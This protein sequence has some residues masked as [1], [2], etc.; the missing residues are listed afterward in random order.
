MLDEG[1][2]KHLQQYSISKSREMDSVSLEDDE[3]SQLSG[4]EGDTVASVG[5]NLTSNSQQWGHLPSSTHFS[6]NYIDVVN[7][8]TLKFLYRDD[9][10]IYKAACNESGYDLML[11]PPDRKITYYFKRQIQFR[12]EFFFLSRIVKAVRVRRVVLLAEISKIQ[13]R[14]KELQEFI[15]VCKKKMDFHLNRLNLLEKELTLLT[16]IDDFKFNCSFGN[17]LCH[18]SGWN[19]I[20]PS[21][22]KEYAFLKSEHVASFEIENDEQKKNSK[23]ARLGL[24]LNEFDSVW[25]VLKFWQ[26]IISVALIARLGLDRYRLSSQE[27]F[28]VANSAYEMM[29]IV[30]VKVKTLNKQQSSIIKNQTEEE[31][32]ESKP[33]SP[34][35][36]RHERLNVNGFRPLQPLLSGGETGLAS[37]ENI[38]SFLGVSFAGTSPFHFVVQHCAVK[39]LEMMSSNA[40]KFLSILPTIVSKLSLSNTIHQ[41]RNSG[42]IISSNTEEFLENS[43]DHSKLDLSSEYQLALSNALLNIANDLAVYLDLILREKFRNLSNE[44]WSQTL[45]IMRRERVKKEGGQLQ[46][47]DNAEVEIDAQGTIRIIPN[48]DEIVDTSILH[49]SMQR[50]KVQIALPQAN[51]LLSSLLNSESNFRAELCAIVQY[52][53]SFTAP[54]CQRIVR[55]F[56]VQMRTSRFLLPQLVINSMLAAATAIQARVRGI[57]GRHKIQAFKKSRIEQAVMLIQ[58]IIR[59]YL[60][61]RRGFVIIENAKNKLKYNGALAIQK[62]FRGFVGRRKVKETLDA[63]QQE[64]AKELDSWAATEIQRIARGHIVRHGILRSIRIRQGL[65]LEVLNKAERY[66][67]KGRDLWGFLKDIDETIKRQQRELENTVR[68]EDESAETFLNKVVVLRQREFDKAWETFACSRQSNLKSPSKCAT[69]TPLMT[70]ES[71]ATADRDFSCTFLNQVPPGPVLR[72]AISVSYSSSRNQSAASGRTRGATRNFKNKSK[73][74]GKLQQQVSN[75]SQSL[76][77]IELLNPLANSTVT[78]SEINKSTVGDVAGASVLI[79]IPNGLEDRLDRLVKAAAL[80]C[81]VP[82]IFAPNSITCEDAYQLYLQLPK[83]S[84]A[85]IRYEQKT[86][87]WIQPILTSLRV[88]GLNLIKDAL[89]SSKLK[90]FLKG[91]QASRDLIQKCVELL[92]DLKKIGKFIEGYSDRESTL[93]LDNILHPKQAIQDGTAQLA[94]PS[95]NPIIFSP[96]HSPTRDKMRSDFAQR[97]LE[98]LFSDGQW[99]KEDSPV[100]HLLQHAAFLVCAF[101]KYAL[102]PQHIAQMPSSVDIFHFNDN[103]SMEESK[104]GQEAFKAFAKSLNDLHNEEDIKSAVKERYRNAVILSTPFELKLKDIGVMTVKDIATYSVSAEYHASS[105]QIVEIINSMPRPYRNQVEA[106][107]SS[108]IGKMISSSVLPVEPVKASLPRT[109]L[110]TQRAP[111]VTEETLVK[112]VPKQKLPNNIDVPLSFDPKFQRGPFDPRGRP[113]RLPEQLPKLKRKSK[114]SPPTIHGI[115]HINMNLI[116]SQTDF[117]N[118]VNISS[119]I[120]D[121]NHIP[122]G[123]WNMQSTYDNPTSGTLQQDSI[124]EDFPSTKQ[125]I[126]KPVTNLSHGESHDHVHSNIGDEPNDAAARVKK[127]N[128]TLKPIYKSKESN[129]VTCE[130][131]ILDMESSFD[132]PFKCSFEG[133]QERFSRLYTLKIHEKSHIIFPGYYKYKRDPMVAYD[134]TIEDMVKDRSQL[135]FSRQTL[136]N[137]REKEVKLLLS[138]KKTLKNSLTND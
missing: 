16:P 124:F 127:K 32:S 103:L 65:S 89:P 43:C 87:Q 18:P 109:A 99:M 125:F 86:Y 88:K 91:C 72:K 9:E 114:L 66:L 61:R 67:T 7:P 134:A 75:F 24:T 54:Y 19:L 23:S 110:Y 116:P 73:S 47:R 1:Q 55:R 36:V 26:L 128:L 35:R 81:Y 137:A 138:K 27:K 6:I 122:T 78:K 30:D 49:G 40:P 100:E 119:T 17:L 102:P 118:N 51:V 64:K 117:Y 77:S 39:C 63:A 34:D 4:F 84:L 25:S 50:L 101:Q 13:E 22:L 106:L 83:N 38:C 8:T 123:L 131:V 76:S 10:T 5:T 21:L 93:Q 42:W 74:R 15:I 96:V 132:R 94:S 31:E 108:A 79:D 70:A 112:Y 14:I 107:I 95:S 57:A 97:L 113:C 28:G 104:L 58:K 41:L 80:R 52:A 136:P 135:I 129:N 62:V 33:L 12:E 53:Y 37:W 59:G 98:K 90:M 111:K 82:D 3:V 120:E 68:L 29:R 48:A 46:L 92:S 130:N 2:Q 11:F 105:A 133:C 115:S 85:R 56:I 71:S 69:L 126:Y 20:V 60:G 45:T 121:D 44:S